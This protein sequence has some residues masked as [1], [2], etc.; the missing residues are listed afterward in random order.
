MSNRILFVSLLGLWAIS[1]V[2]GPLF[3]F[4]QME[5]NVTVCLC[6]GEEEPG[7]SITLDEL[8]EKVLNHQSMLCTVEVTSNSEAAPLTQEVVAF[9]IP[10]EIHLP[11]PE[12]P[13]PLYS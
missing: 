10:M 5:D 6:T 11:P 4:S 1:V 12:A 2:S 8:E 13:A 9:G 3:L 7:S